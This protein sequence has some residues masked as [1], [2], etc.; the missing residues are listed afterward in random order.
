VWAE[1]GLG[2]QVLMSIMIP[3]ASAFAD[4]VV[5]EIDPR[6]VPLLA[7]S[8]AGVTVVP[9][10]QDLFDGPVAA[11]CALGDLARY[12][13]PDAQSFE[14]SAGGYLQV[15]RAHADKLRARLRQD[16]R[17]IV[18]LSWSSANREIGHSKSARLVDLAP[19]LRLSNCTFVDLQYGDTRKDREAVEAATGVHIEHIDDIDNTNDIDGLAALMAACDAVVSVSNTNAHLAAAQ[20]RPVLLLLSDATGLIWYWMKRGESTPF[21]AS[22]RL[23]RRR[24]GQTWAELAASEVAPALNAYLDGLPR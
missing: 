4:R 21:Y 14:K 22:A 2:D 16:G 8:F 3:D 19:V 10:Q 23:F 15:D 1:V 5:L 12:L 9:Q 18:G 13:R 7:R 11:Q 24:S 17:R 6:L 20:G